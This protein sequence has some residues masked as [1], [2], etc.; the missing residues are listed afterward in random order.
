MSRLSDWLTPEAVLASGELG[1]Y[2]GLPATIVVTTALRRG[3][4]CRQSTHWRGRSAAHV[5]CHP[6]GPPRPS[7]PGNLRQGQSDRALP[8]QAA[9]ITGQRIVL[10][11][12]AGRF[13]DV[14]T[15]RKAPAR[16]HPAILPGRVRTCSGLR[17]RLE[18][19]TAGCIRGRR[20]MLRPWVF[21]TA[22][23]IGSSAPESALG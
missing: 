6:A 22:Y 7:L 16:L 2:N 8:H 11:A 5:R 21:T 14:Y 4:R 17:F 13:A 12:C 23:L 19:I 3:I 18:R 9:R 10:Y 1:Q 20:H 15:S